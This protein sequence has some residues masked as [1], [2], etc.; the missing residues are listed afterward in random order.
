MAEQLEKLDFLGDSSKDR[1]NER[2]NIDGDTKYKSTLGGFCTVSIAVIFMLV[3][4]AELGH[5]A[6]RR[7]P[8]TSTREVKDEY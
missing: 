1:P 3:L 8:A 6:K 5:V 7:F 2:L 4:L